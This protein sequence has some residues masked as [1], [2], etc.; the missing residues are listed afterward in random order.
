MILPLRWLKP[1]PI[2][3]RGGIIKLLIFAVLLLLL[4]F[5]LAYLYLI[6]HFVPLP[7]AD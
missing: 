3:S 2:Q 5:A 4:G 1:S 7:T 6:T